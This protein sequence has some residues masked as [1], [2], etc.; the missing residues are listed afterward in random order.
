MYQF[1]VHDQALSI[2]DRE[3][4]AIVINIG[5]DQLFHLQVFLHCLRLM[6]TLYWLAFSL[7]TAANMHTSILCTFLS[8]LS[9]SSP[10]ETCGYY[11]ANNSNLIRASFCGG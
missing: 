4:L 2:Q 5:V 8:F 11:F 3:N 9:V 6:S 7:C 10:G 1:S